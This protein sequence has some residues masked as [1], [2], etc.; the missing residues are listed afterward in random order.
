MGVPRF[1][2]RF[3]FLQADLLLLKRPYFQQIETTQRIEQRAK[4]KQQ[5]EKRALVDFFFFLFAVC[6]ISVGLFLSV[7]AQL[8]GS[9]RVRFRAIKLS[10]LPILIFAVSCTEDLPTP[11]VLQIPTISRIEAPST[12]FQTPATPQHISVFVN[13]PQGPDDIAEVTLAIKQLST[14]NTVAQSALNDDGQNGDVLANDGVYFV[15]FAASLTQNAA[16]D[17]LIEAQA[18]DQSN[19]TSEVVRD[20]MTVVSGAEN[21]APVLLMAFSPDTVWVDSVYTFQFQATANDVDGLASLRPLL[22]QVFP[23]AFPNP[24]ITDSLFDDG[25]HDDGGA[26]DGTFANSFAPTFFNKGRGR[27]EVLFRARDNAGGFSNA[28]IRRVE[29]T[30]RFVNDPPQVSGL[31][32]PDLISRSA[33]PNT[34][35]LSVLAND[36]DGRLDIQRVFFNTFLPNGNPSSG[37]PFNMRD[38]GQQGDATANDGRYSL[39][40]EINNAAATGNYRFEFQAQDKQG[41]LSTKLIHSITVIN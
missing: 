18:R 27:Y 11:V 23:P 15:L 17:F 33:T 36:P 40:I 35:V 9:R 1:L 6:L 28:V 22:I 25:A 41:A 38:D 21:Q 5:K 14:G 3:R 29:V 30:D 2:R 31:Q 24:A 39:T 34:Y 26:N 13:D 32:A 16:G 8:L 4:R 19:N 10:I 37:N 12:V 20:T 7:G